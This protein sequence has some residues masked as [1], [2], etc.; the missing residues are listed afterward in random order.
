MVDKQEDLA[1]P[2]ISTYEEVEIL[3][4]TIIKR[5]GA[6]EQYSREKVEKGLRKALEKRP[7]TQEEF[8]NLVS[9]I[10]KDLQ[11]KRKSEIKSKD[12]GEIIMKWLK[13]Q[14][15][16]AYIRF[17]SVYRSFKDVKTFYRELDKLSKKHVKSGKGN[18]VK[19]K[20]VKHKNVGKR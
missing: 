4:L 14:D 9:K 2:G 1:G 18:V 16:V 13:K 6:K 12:V 11:L 3:D 5:D 19:K 8:K 7:I 10:E 20:K 17:A 15:G